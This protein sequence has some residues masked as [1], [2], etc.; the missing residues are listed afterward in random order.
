MNWTTVILCIILLFGSISTQAQ[1]QEINQVDEKGRKHGKWI[2]KYPN[3]QSIYIGKFKHGEPVEIFK[4]YYPNGSFQAIMKYRTSDTVFAELYNKNEQKQ[5]E[6][7]Y[8]K[9]Q[10]DSTW[11]LY[12]DNGNIIS[13]DTYDK[14]SRDGQSLKFYPDGDTSQIMR[15]DSGKKHGIFK[16]FFDNGNVKMHGRYVD[17]LL[18][19][20]LTLY[21]PNGYKKVE[22]R[23]KE[24]LREGDWVYYNEHGDTSEVITYQKGV[25][26]NQD[27]LERIQTKEINELEKNE[28]KFENPRDQFY[29]N[30]EIR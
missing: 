4:R 17:G 2:K 21:Y 7:I 24:N 6:G 10:K 5:A 13:K 27:S 26:E 28:G 23:Y 20:F 30:R 14:G 29:N 18:D 9:K 8:I 1:S 11:N 19:G 25:P 15:W 16:Q 3:G 22:G 12:D